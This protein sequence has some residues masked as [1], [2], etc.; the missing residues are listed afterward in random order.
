MPGA[1]AQAPALHCWDAPQA[2]PGYG[3]Y[4]KAEY[5]SG[6][7]D[8]AI[9]AFCEHAGRA[10]SPRGHRTTSNRDV[11]RRASEKASRVQRGQR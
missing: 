5:L 6:L 8:E 9:D 4:W 11:E 7:P 2:L 1:H 3:N 10:T